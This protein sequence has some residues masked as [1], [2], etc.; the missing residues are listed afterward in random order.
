M[1]SPGIELEQK[2]LLKKFITAHQ[3]KN[4]AQAQNRESSADSDSSVCLSDRKSQS[5]DEGDVLSKSGKKVKLSK[6]AH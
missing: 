5:S 3:N 1:F 4:A 2:G 6:Q